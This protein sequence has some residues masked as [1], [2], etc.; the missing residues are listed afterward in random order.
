MWTLLLVLLFDSRDYREVG[1]YET[2]EECMVVAQESPWL[3]SMTQMLGSY[4]RFEVDGEA[5]E[6]E[7]E[8][9]E[10]PA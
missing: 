1:T 10:R 2:L 6:V 4:C 9:E 3:G 7:P 8:E 5:D